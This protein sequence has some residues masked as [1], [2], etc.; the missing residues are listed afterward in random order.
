M[1]TALG[2]SNGSAV[3]GI[4]H[5][6]IE[7]ADAERAARFY[8]DTLGVDG[9]ALGDWPEAN[10]LALALPSGQMLVFKSGGTGDSQNESGIHQAYGCTPEAR[11]AIEASLAGTG[12]AVHRYHEDRPAEARDPF[13]FTDP[14]GNRVQLVAAPGNQRGISGIDHAAIQA[15]DMEWEE[16]FFVDRLG[17]AVDH[18]VGW[19]TED[20]VRARAWAEGRDDMAPGTR[21]M[22]RRYRDNPGAEPGSSREVPRPNIQLF[23]SLGGSVLGI[24]LATSHVQEPAPELARGTPRTAL[25]MDRAGLESMA[26]ALDAA[27]VALEG[28]VVHDKGAPL[29]VSLYFRDPCGNFFEL[30]VPADGRG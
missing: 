13:Y 8:A 27:G 21:R 6:V 24:F 12:I 14:D 17:F 11:S 28:P 2:S 7:V 1:N 25:A 19:N 23:L 4:S 26:S 30:C 9:A 20:Y 18:R 5:L 15:S 22:D 3:H 16:A 10:E 29:E